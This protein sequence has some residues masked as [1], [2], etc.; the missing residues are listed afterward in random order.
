MF[1]VVCVCVFFERRC[2]NVSERVLTCFTIDMFIS[3]YIYMLYIY[4]IYI[5]RCLKIYN[6]HC[7]LFTLFLH[8][9]SGTC[10]VLETNLIFQG[11]AFHFHDYGR[12]GTKWPVPVING[13]IDMDVSENSGSPKSSILIGVSFIN[14]P[15]WGTL[16]FGNTRIA[17]LSRVK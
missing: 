7:L 15:F 2:E 16:F 13:G 11:P 12:K 17:P 14:Q 9:R 1:S 5:Y 4:V 3:I 8:H 6:L 10:S